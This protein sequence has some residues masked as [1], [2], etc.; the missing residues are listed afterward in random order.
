VKLLR[1]A[2]MT[3]RDLIGRRWVLVLFLIV[4]MVFYTARRGDAGW[5]GIR[6]ACMGL[7]WAVSTVSLFSYQS[8][9]GLEPRLRL[10]GMP[11]WSLFFGRWLALTVVALLVGTVYAVIVVLDQEPLNGWAVTV[12]LLVSAC[13]SVPLGLLVGILV[14]RDF[15]G[16]L[17][18][19]M[20]VG[21]QMIVDPD[22]TLA[23]VLPLWSTREFLTYGIEGSADLVKAWRHAVVYGLGLA[24]SGFAI[25]LIRL[26]RRSHLVRLTNSGTPGSDRVFARDVDQGKQRLLGDR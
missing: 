4:P 26:R 24:A 12:A 6:M 19:I 10:A 5:Q 13:L 8:A 2:E 11:S 18:L 21:L 1:T 17:I 22:R 16:M 15:E 3:L 23:Q 7:A 25:T 9:R 20:I 14:P